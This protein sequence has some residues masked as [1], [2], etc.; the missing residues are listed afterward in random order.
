M[1]LSHFSLKPE[2]NQKQ[3]DTAMGKLPGASQPLA[4][5]QQRKPAAVCETT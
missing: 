5:A 1:G 4:Q 3:L 2:D